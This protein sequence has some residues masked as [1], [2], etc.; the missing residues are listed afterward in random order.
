MIRI[1][2]NKGAADGNALPIGTPILNTAVYLLDE[3]L[4]QV[5][6]GMPGEICIGGSGVALGYYQNEAMTSAAFVETPLLPGYKLYKTGDYGRMRPSGQIEF[7][8]RR[9]GQVKIM[10]YRVETGEIQNVLCKMSD[11]VRDAVVV[12]VKIDT[13]DPTSKATHELRGFVLVTGEHSH[14]SY[15]YY[16]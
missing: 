3:N 8:S 1:R 13:E 4:Q 5:P 12:P 14:E 11:F 7:I 10:G 16:H 15:L 9:D 2:Y 6:V